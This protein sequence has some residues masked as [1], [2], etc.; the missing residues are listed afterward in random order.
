MGLLLGIITGILFGF[1]LQKAQAIRF[2]RQVGFLLLKD[3]TIIKFML[4]AIMVGAV[5]IYLCKDLGII[6]FSIKATDVAAQIIGGL[7]FGI[8]WAIAGYCPGTSL[9]AL[10][11][12]RIHALWA[13]LGM[14]VGAGLYAEVYPALKSNVL[15]WGNLGKI[16]VPDILKINHWVIIFI[17][18]V[19]ILMLFKFFQN[20]NI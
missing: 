15:A 7:L 11:E 12:G 6:S 17:F 8:G 19:A 9:G 13:I 10:G 20:K 5:G 1:F 2:E 18:I 4:S 16:T 3:M 14:L